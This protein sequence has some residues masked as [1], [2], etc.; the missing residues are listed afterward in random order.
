VSYKKQKAL[1]IFIGV[2]GNEHPNVTAS[3]N[4]TSGRFVQKKV[5]SD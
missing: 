4:N 2:Y 1:A 5:Y 3:L